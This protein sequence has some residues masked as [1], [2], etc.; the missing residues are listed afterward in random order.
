MEVVNITILVLLALGAAARSAA[1]V[2]DEWPS[3]RNERPASTT[4]YLEKHGPPNCHK[5]WT[6]SIDGV[7]VRLTWGRLSGFGS[8]PWERTTCLTMET[9]TLARKEAI[10]RL[11]VKL[12]NGYTVKKGGAK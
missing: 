7:E 5:F 8:L 9:P 1:A 11:K 3:S 2:N 12:R 4:L 10:R 6:V